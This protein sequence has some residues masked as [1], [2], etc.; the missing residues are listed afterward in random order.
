MTFSH[1]P[2]L[3]NET[4]DGLNIKSDGI[5]VDA[6]FGRGGHSR[7]ILKRLGAN[8][9]LFALDRDLAAI[10]AAKS[11][12]DDRFTIVHAPF[13]QIKEVCKA[14]GILE[15]VNGILM[16][17]GVSSPQLDDASRGFSFDKD[18]P[19][20]MRMDQSAG[21]DAAYI[22]NTYAAKDL[23]YIFKTYGEER[24]A[25]K[26]ANAIVRQREKAP[27]TTTLA[28]AEVISAAI[29]GKPGPKHKATRCFQ[30][31]RIAVNSELDELKA[32]LEGSLDVLS[33]DGRLCVISFH[34]LEDRIVKTFIREN[35]EGPKLPRGLPVTDAELAE[36][37]RQSCK[38]IKISGAVKASDDEVSQ[39]P[40]S[41]SAVL[42]VAAR[43]GRI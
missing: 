9:R 29:P 25:G 22:V 7:E 12:A 35:S 41:R 36:L 3:L 13:S 24:F 39:N 30:A 42:R 8:G 34:S 16:D 37:K 11:I 14:C 15:K 40:R 43:L 4:I 23:A 2:V 6:T 5:Y 10:E 17:I 21:I 26:V 18:G 33:D 32:A 28:L 31:L 20:D 27:F 38:L 1:I 19:L